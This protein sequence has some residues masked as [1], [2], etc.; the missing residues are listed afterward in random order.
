MMEWK[1]GPAKQANQSIINKNQTF[2]VCC[3]DWWFA[4]FG[5]RPTILFENCPPRWMNQ[6]FHSLPFISCFLQSTHPQSKIKLSLSLMKEESWLL[7]AFSL[8][9]SRRAAHSNCFHF[10]QSIFIPV[11]YFHKSRR[12]LLLMNGEKEWMIWWMKESCFLHWINLI[13]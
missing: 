5:G 10:V 7:L 9:A 1:E 11:N 6:T 8:P 2:L 13:N 4:C 3:V 12:R